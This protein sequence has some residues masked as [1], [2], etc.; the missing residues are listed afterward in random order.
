MFILSACKK[1]EKFLIFCTGKNHRGNPTPP[2]P[3]HPRHPEGLEGAGERGWRRDSSKTDQGGGWGVDQGV[4]KV[5]IKLCSPPSPSLPVC[6]LHALD[7][8]MPVSFVLSFSPPPPLPQSGTALREQPVDIYLF[9]WCL[10]KTIYSERVGVGG[11][12]GKK[13]DVRR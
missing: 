10:L 1:S 5:Q 11:E 3:L 8:L 7:F 13:K 9:C 6:D 12:G 4:Q 2:T